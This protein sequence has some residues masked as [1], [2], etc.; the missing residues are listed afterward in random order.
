MIGGDS[1]LEVVIMIVIGIVIRVPLGLIWLGFLV[2]A[3]VDSIVV[4]D[5]CT[6]LIC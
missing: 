1:V 3:G 6:C 5:Y 4:V 2:G